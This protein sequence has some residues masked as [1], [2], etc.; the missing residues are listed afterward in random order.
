MSQS[1]D[2]IL[3]DEGSQYDDVEM[4]RLFQSIQEQPHR[5]FTT[6]VADMQQL[7]P[8]VSGVFVRSLVSSLQS[9]SL[10]TVYRS[11]DATHLEFL[12]R[13]RFKQPTRPLLDEYFAGRIW[14]GSLEAAVGR[15]MD[16]SRSAARPFI[17]L[18]STN[19]GA[20]E[21]CGAAVR[22]VGITDAELK[23]GFLPDP[24][25]K[26]NLRIVARPGVLVRLTRNEDKDKGFV[27]GAIGEVCESLRGNAVFSV[28][29][30]ETGNRVLVSPMEEDGQVFL[31]C[32]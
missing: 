5:P 2:C 20:A 9:V 31:P 32:C 15:S 25:S 17:W 6:I 12:H 22:N 27:N 14:R 1:K 28:R 10:E 11:K 4:Q 21:V 30:L 23:N 26:S 29:L 19:R 18:C 24:T 13:I 3:I 16:I 7:Q 8:L